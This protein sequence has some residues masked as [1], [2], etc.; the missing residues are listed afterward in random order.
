M[1]LSRRISGILCGMIAFCCLSAGASAEFFQAPS[2]EIVSAWKLNTENLVVV[3]RYDGTYYLVDGDPEHPGMERGTFEWDNETGAFSVNT[4]IDTNGDAGFSHPGAATTVTVSGNTLNYTV[5]GEGTFS[6]TRVVNPA[7]AIVGSWTIPGEKLSVTFLADLS[8]Y[9]TQEANDIPSGYSGMEK[10]TYTWN[11]TTKAFTATAPIDMNGDIGLNG[12]NF[13]MNITGN[14]LEIIDGLEIITLTRI[15]TN[16]TP[17]RLPDFGTVRFANYVQSSNAAPALS[18][19]NGAQDSYPYSAEVFVDPAVGATAPTFKI[20]AG[21]PIVIDADLDD[22][23]SFEIEQGYATLAELNTILPAST[24]IQFKNG[25]STANLTTG[26]PPL[27][28]PS[29][30]KILVGS[31][32]SFSS[33]VYRF[34][35]N[36]VL[37]WTLPTGFDASKFVTG[38]FISDATTGQDV[39]DAELHGD[40]TFL[41]L[42]GRLEPGKQYD[43]ELEFYRLDTSTTAGTGVFAG[44]QGYTISAS[45]TYFK[46]RSRNV[47]PEGP[48]IFEQPVSQAGTTGSP[49]RLLVG[50]NEGAFPFST[51]RWFRNNQE[52]EGQTGNSLFIPGFNPDEHSGRYKVVVSNGQGQTESNLANVGRVGTNS[53]QVQYIV[54]YKLKRSE[55][56]SAT[57]LTP[58]GASFDARVEGIGI[59]ATF[60]S[61]NITLTKPAGSTVPLMLDEDHWDAETDFASFTALQTAFPNG[62]YKINIGSDSIPI[63]LSATNYPNQPL[64]T[65]SVGTWVNG[66]LQIT[67]SQAAAG[68]TLTS[69]STTG[70]GFVDLS[71]IDIATDSDIIYAV[72]NTNPSD[73]ANTLFVSAT[74]AP[75]QITV[76]KSYEVDVEFDEVTDSANLFN[77]SWG[78]PPNGVANAFGLLSTT[79]TFTLEVVADP[80][81]TPYTTWQAGFFN[82]TQL[83]NPAIS[84][85]DVDFDLDGID[86]LIEFILGGS[87]TATNANILKN[88]TTT[89]APGGRNLVF[90]YDR[91][92]AANGITQVIETSPTLSGIWTPAVHGAAGVVISTSPLDAQTE[93]V[94]ATI[95]STETKLFV[96]MKAT[97]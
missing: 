13:T 56:Q 2:P 50:I 12:A 46:V 92:T 33:G 42:G 82:P 84:G 76:G 7:S 36:E 91:K 23:G 65:S 30:P 39:V 37:Q 32:A 47:F 78:A 83:A 54:A 22:P 87:P 38:V 6:F 66:K 40:V 73:P 97:R 59:T 26:A 86:N 41:D 74:I 51:F 48:S 19:F 1:N 53:Q 57:L 3:F 18:P 28:F 10:G 95:P 44:K 88:A 11:S 24:A 85:D 75:N 31:G 60:P 29:I 34:G 81:G 8:Y 68:F 93:R 17:L 4:I 69:N 77:Q 71:V 21:A 72:A 58:T 5:P 70:D 52:I 49:L 61:N 89:P 64:V 45:S 15:T 67:A 55:Q 20:G 43:V 94:T 25:T 16:P 80:A 96:R 14:T 27:T 62:I 35:D 9:F 63:D 79:T 90:S